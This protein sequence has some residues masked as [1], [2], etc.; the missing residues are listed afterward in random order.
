MPDYKKKKRN[1]LVTSR[2]SSGKK[3]LKNNNDDIIMSSSKSEHHDKENKIKVIKGRKQENQAKLRNT[4]VVVVFVAV[5]LVLLQMLLP[6]GIFGTVSQAVSLIGTGSYP[7]STSGSSICNIISKDSYYYVLTNTEVAAYTNSGKELFKY[8][9]GF[10]NPIIKTSLARA[11]VF[12][13]GSTGAVICDM[14]SVKYTVTSTK[15]ILTAAVSDSG[16]YALVTRSDKYASTV[17]VY[18]KSGKEVYEWYS[19][20]N[21]V[22]NVAISKN[23]KKIAVSS[24]NSDSG[25]YISNVN[26]LNFKSATPEFSEKLDDKLVYNL[27]TGANS[28]FFA[29]TTNG[30]E[31]IKWSNFKK[32]DYTNEYDTTFFKSGKGGFVGVYNRVSDHT[33]N[34]IAVFTKSGKLK[35]E[36]NFKG[37]ISDIGVRD[38]HIYCICDNKLIQ[39]D[40]DASVL[41][42]ADC[43]FGANL[44]TVTGAN[45]V[46]FACDDKIDNISL[47]KK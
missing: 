17:T 7:I 11:I 13:Q 43:G 21:T 38:G 22:N 8:K 10:E 15:P 9:H 1:K 18:K 36:I 44:L 20:E 16:N 27:E 28:G 26:V 3:H 46:A 33:D 31:F 41:R 29:V 34:R 37:I 42:E 12:D 39:I 25:K 2:R 45:T 40:S 32:K 19:A 24:F 35:Y 47:N 6:L 23:G 14:N 4:A 5:A 30:V